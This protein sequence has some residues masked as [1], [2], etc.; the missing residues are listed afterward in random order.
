M[1]HH[2]N[3]IFEIMGF[4]RIFWKNCVQEAYLAK[5]CISGQIVSEIVRSPVM[6]RKLHTNPSKFFVGRPLGKHRGRV[7]WSLVKDVTLLYSMINALLSS[8]K[9]LGL[10]M[11]NFKWKDM[12]LTI[13]QDIL[14]WENKSVLFKKQAGHSGLNTQGKAK[15]FYTW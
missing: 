10:Q 8:F 13:G 7:V 15:S 6:L 12:C 3:E 9:L 1:W 2:K 5:M 11:S 14:A 4:L